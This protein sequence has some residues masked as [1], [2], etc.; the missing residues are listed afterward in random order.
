MKENRKVGKQK[1][2]TGQ[3]SKTNICECSCWLQ[4]E[5]RNQPSSNCRHNSNNN[6]NNNRQQEHDK[7]NSA[8]EATMCTC[9][10]LKKRW[11][12]CS[13][14]ST[15]DILNGMSGKDYGDTSIV[16]EGDE[17]GWGSAVMTKRRD[18]EEN[19]ELKKQGIRRLSEVLK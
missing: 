7:K 5:A 12:R 9:K 13:S 11:I 8:L 14:W 17:Q 4:P 19:V 6:N 1:W 15:Y 18:Q 10:L 16:D 3:A 2:N